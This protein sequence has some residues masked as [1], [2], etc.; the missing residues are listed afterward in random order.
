MKRSQT[1]FHADTM[2]HSKVVRLN[3]VKIYRKVKIFLQQ[4]FFLIIDTLLKLQPH[5]L[6]CFCKFSCNSEIL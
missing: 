1:K 2:S 6:T 4:C 5:I 3:K